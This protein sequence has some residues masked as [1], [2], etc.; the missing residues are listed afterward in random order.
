M[1]EVVKSVA[2]D[3]NGSQKEVKFACG[4]GKGMVGEGIKVLGII[5]PIRQGLLLLIAR[6]MNKVAVTMIGRVNWSF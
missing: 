2:K 4:K 1:K 5:P 6:V 3:K